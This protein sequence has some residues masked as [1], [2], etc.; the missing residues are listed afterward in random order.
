MANTGVGVGT[1]RLGLYPLG[2][3]SK[4]NKMLAGEQEFVIGNKNMPR[5]WCNSVPGSI[6]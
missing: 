6:K 3:K 5:K 4:R 1:L 2:R